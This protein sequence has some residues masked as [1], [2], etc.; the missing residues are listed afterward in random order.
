MFDIANPN[1]LVAEIES[2]HRQESVLVARRMAAVAALLRHRVAATERAEHRR[3]YAV[4]DGF[5]QTAAEVAAAM[6]LSPVAASYLVSYAEAL[7]IR[8]PKLAALLAE[9]RTDWRTVR[10]IISRTDL[11]TDEALIAET[12]AGSSSCP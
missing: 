5:E 8:L 1:A 12:N 10:L 2:T 11:I 3:G 7:D 4:I 6:N 9:G